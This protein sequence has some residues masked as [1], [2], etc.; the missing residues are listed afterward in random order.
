MCF[1]VT[2]LQAT[3]C[4]LHRTVIRTSSSTSLSVIWVLVNH[5][6]CISSPRKSVSLSEILGNPRTCHFGRFCASFEGVHVEDFFFVLQLCLTVHIR[7]ASNLVPA[8]STF[9]VRKSNYKSGILLDRNDF[10]LWPGELTN[11]YCIVEVEIK[12]FP[13]VLENCVLTYT[14]FRS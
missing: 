2:H 12:S 7:L 11:W 14:R 3:I 13:R 10:V 9:V 8:S 6:Y 1:C 5:V 4:P